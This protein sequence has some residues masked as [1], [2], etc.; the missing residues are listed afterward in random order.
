MSV[1]INLNIFFYGY[2]I[3]SHKFCAVDSGV[4]SRGQAELALG[5][6]QKFA[7]RTVHPLETR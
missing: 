1:A 6:A 3:C 2:K 5:P 4:K 7:L